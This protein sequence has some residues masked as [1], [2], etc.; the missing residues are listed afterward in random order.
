MRDTE[1]LNA[2]VDMM[3]VGRNEQDD[4]DFLFERERAADDDVGPVPQAPFPLDP[5]R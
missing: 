4:P 1:L 3:G 5:P 2:Y